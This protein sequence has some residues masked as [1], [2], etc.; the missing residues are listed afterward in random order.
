MIGSITE[1]AVLCAAGHVNMQSS[2]TRVSVGGLHQLNLDCIQVRIT[3]WRGG[4][5]ALFAFSTG[6]WARIVVSSTLYTF[7]TMSKMAISLRTVDRMKVCMP[8]YREWV[9]KLCLLK[10]LDILKN[11]IKYLLNWSMI[12]RRIPCKWESKSQP[13]PPDERRRS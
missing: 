5:Y 13:H 3:Y 6:R 9:I 12:T 4:D 8:T 7:Y 2:P 10:W 11:K 1:A